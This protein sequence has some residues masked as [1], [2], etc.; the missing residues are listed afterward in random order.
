ML[1]VRRLQHDCMQIHSTVDVNKEKSEI[2]MTDNFVQI[3]R[4]WDKSP[5]HTE[6]K[7]K[8]NRYLHTILLMVLLLKHLDLCWRKTFIKIKNRKTQKIR[9]KHCSLRLM[10]RERVNLTTFNRELTFSECPTR[11]HNVLFVKAY[12]KRQNLWKVRYSAVELGSNL[13]SQKTS[14]SPVVV[15]DYFI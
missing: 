4:E 14:R 1:F 9:A 2:W 11:K 6:W 8:R 10:L 13:K 7:W 12:I 3:K 5:Y 15:N